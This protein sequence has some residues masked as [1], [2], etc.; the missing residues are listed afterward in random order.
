MVPPISKN[1][2]YYLGT[3]KNHLQLAQAQVCES[4][5][6]LYALVHECVCVCS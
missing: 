4:V 1:Q 5:W 3:T 6:N 2:S